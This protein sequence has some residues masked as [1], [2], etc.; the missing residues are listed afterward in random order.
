MRGCGFSLFLKVI[1][2]GTSALEAFCGMPD[3]RN[4]FE[5]PF[6][7]LPGSEDLKVGEQVYLQDQSGQPFRL[8]ANLAVPCLPGELH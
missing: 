2:S 3:P 8:S 7:D 1:P 6:T 5:I 4:I